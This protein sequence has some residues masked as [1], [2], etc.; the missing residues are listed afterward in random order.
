MQRYGGQSQQKWKKSSAAY[1]MPSYYGHGHGS[2]V[3]NANFGNKRNR[4]I[5]T[6]AIGV[7]ILF[8]ISYPAGSVK[9]HHNASDSSTGSDEEKRYKG[10]SIAGDGHHT[11]NDAAAPKVEPAASKR[12][13]IAYLLTYPMSGSTYTMLLVSKITNATLATNYAFNSHAD[14]KDKKHT[15]SL[16]NQEQARV[17]G[18]PIWY[19]TYGSTTK[20]TNN[21]LTLSH[22]AGH[23]MYPCHP[24]NYVQTEVSF[25]ETCRSIIDE[26]DVMMGDDGGYEIYVT[27]KTD[28]SK[29]IHLIRDPFSNI[30]SRYH[31]YLLEDNSKREA[32]KLS[33]NKEGF[34][35]WCLEMDAN[36]KLSELDRE[37]TFINYEVKELMKD[38]PC[39]SEFY[40]YVSWHN[41]VMNMAQNEH[42][43]IM[44]VYYED[45]AS[46]SK[47]QQLAMKMAGFLEEPIVNTSN[48]TP[49]TMVLRS[50][51][52]Y[53]TDEERLSAEKLV[54]SM[55]L[56]T[57]W[58]VL[59]RY[60]NEEEMELEEDTEGV[61]GEA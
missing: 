50:Y 55:A 2:N 23:C 41:H 60:F 38:V 18:S 61:D 14:K 33:P 1:Q 17:P 30:V 22:C 25:E 19:T 31:E 57:T 56:M 7:F 46:K 3:Y 59:E 51:R 42:Y 10:I 52:D 5:F 54:K 43:P 32:S 45:Y 12:L 8:I 26:S 9:R 37:A 49:S 44:Q 36:V 24:E 28:I 21:L 16:N 11:N 39:R 40:K 20:P 58:D 53:Y 27:P 4:L 48:L 47:E 29:I 6:F 35:D 13:K 15:S 34:K